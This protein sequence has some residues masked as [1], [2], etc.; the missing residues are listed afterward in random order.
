[1]PNALRGAAI[2]LYPEAEKIAIA[3]GVETALAIR[4]ATGWPVWA[5]ISAGGMETL[6]LPAVIREILIG[7]D[8]DPNGRGQQAA[9][10]LARRLCDR[11]AT[12]IMTPPVI[13]ADWLDILNGAF[14]EG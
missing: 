11:V 9:K 13:G 6:E 12:R 4:A 2:R 3:E 7:A 5:A 14:D 8:N 10:H 1:M